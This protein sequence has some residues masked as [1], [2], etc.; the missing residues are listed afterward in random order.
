MIIYDSVNWFLLAKISIIG[1]PI[2]LYWNLLYFFICLLLALILWGFE[3]C[4]FQHMGSFENIAYMSLEVHFN[5][6]CVKFCSN[7][8]HFNKI[9]SLREIVLFSTYNFVIPLFHKM[10]SH[11]TY[12]V[13]I[14]CGVSRC[15]LVWP[16]LNEIK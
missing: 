13:L 6:R 12:V 2:F 15:P 14:F 9:F 7:I 8:C 1:S 3:L 10:W 11:H 4:Y 16:S 5:V